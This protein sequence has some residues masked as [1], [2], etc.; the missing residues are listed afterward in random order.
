M[1]RPKHATV[2]QSP[3]KENSHTRRENTYVIIFYRVRK[4]LFVLGNKSQNVNIQPKLFFNKTL[5]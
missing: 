3:E 5:I 2:A 1:S 4:G